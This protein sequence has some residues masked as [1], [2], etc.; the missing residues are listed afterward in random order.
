MANFVSPQVSWRNVDKVN[1]ANSNKFQLAQPYDFGQVDAGYIPTPNDYY[2]F[3]IWNN[4]GNQN[5]NAPKMEDVTIGVKDSGG[6]NGNA[7]GSEVQSINGSVKWFW[8]KVDSLNETDSNFA[9]IG[10][11]LTK[12]IG[13]LGSTEHPKRASVKSWK[14][15]TTFTTGSYIVPTNSNNYMYEVVSGGTTGTLEPT[16][17]ITE[18]ELFI[19]GTL[20]YKAIQIVKTPAKSNEILGVVNDGSLT[21]A[22][23]NYAKVTIKI[24]V[25][26]TAKSGEQRIK[27]R[28]SFRYV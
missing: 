14:A 21:N 20:E 1:P 6:G 5:D 2:S 22:G 15:S 19:D 3:L 17:K 28:T 10:A 13:T 9:Q 16:W 8:A 7:V 25:P 24:E 12:P 23:G 4:Y 18:G 27:L 26:L 11:T